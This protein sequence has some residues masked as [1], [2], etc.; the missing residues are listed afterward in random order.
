[1]YVQIGWSQMFCVW[2]AGGIQPKVLLNKLQRQRTRRE[3]EKCR[4]L[5][6]L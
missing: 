2:R 5:D 4:F 3:S 6:G 1:M